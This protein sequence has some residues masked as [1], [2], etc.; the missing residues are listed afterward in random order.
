VLGS[1]LEPFLLGLTV[2]LAYWMVLFWMYRRN[3]FLRI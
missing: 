3:I 1:G 2:L